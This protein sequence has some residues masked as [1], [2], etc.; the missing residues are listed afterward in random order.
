MCFCTSVTWEAICSTMA[1]ALTSGGSSSMVWGFLLAATGAFLIALCLSEF[2]SMIPTAG[3]QY[4]YVAHL[5]PAK[6]RRIFSWYAGWITMWGWLTSSVSG[7][8]A[9][10]MQIQAYAIIFHPEYHY[11]RWHTSMVRTSL[12]IS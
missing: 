4:H 3:G 5:S 11:E 12:Q 10:S 2:S 7:M 9:M 6:F 1:Q 8:F